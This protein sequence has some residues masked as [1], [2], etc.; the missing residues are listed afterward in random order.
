[1][2]KQQRVIKRYANRKLYDTL[3]SRYVTLDQLAE[4][5]RA[6]EDLSVH[7]NTTK[8]DLTAMTLAQ[9]IFEE[10]R[11]RSVVPLTMLRRIIQSSEESF[12]ELV[13]KLEESAG[14]V[15]RVF[16]RDEVTAAAAAAATPT[17]IS[18]ATA[19]G[20]SGPGLAAGA[21]ATSDAEASPAAQPALP[22][23]ATAL[24][25]REGPGPTSSEG[26]RTVRDLIENIQQTIDEWHR[27]V[28]AN[29]HS[30]I[31]SVSPLVPLQ[32]ELQTLNDRLG[33]IEQR[34]A[35][36]ESV[37]QALAGGTSDDGGT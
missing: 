17:A 25:A 19:G 35:R 12:H 11:R 27:R 2:T 34:L 24:P 36:V 28:D 3:D 33:Q 9:I 23:A 8:E 37:E 4:F 26:G 18:G 30:A 21:A 31:E 6:G 16:R 29:V 1:M 5:I 13:G 10:E 20:T 22:L 32:R 14:R 15:G 7:D